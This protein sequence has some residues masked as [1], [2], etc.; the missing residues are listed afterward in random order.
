MRPTDSDGPPIETLPKITTEL[1]KGLIARHDADADFRWHEETIEWLM[2]QKPRNDEEW[3]VSVKAVL[4][5]DLYDTKA[6]YYYNIAKHIMKIGLDSLLDEGT[7]RAVHA[8]GFVRLDDQDM[9]F[10]TFASNYC[11]WHRPQ[12]YPMM[13]PVVQQVLWSYR[14]VLDGDLTW[15]QLDTYDG[16][17]DALREFQEQ[18]GLQDLSWRELD[19]GL[20]MLGCEALL[21]LPSGLI[22]RHRDLNSISRTAGRDRTAHRL[23]G[24]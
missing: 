9:Q 20:R 23:S 7:S 11:H 4:I 5:D 14:S 13:N 16:F 12:T 6:Y 24:V 2:P 21:G 22:R 15:E 8:L 17:W 19:K 18:L 10:L 3:S 1:L